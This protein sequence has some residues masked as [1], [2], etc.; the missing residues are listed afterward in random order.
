MSSTILHRDELTAGRASRAGPEPAAPERGREERNLSLSI[1]G[2]RVRHLRARRGMTRK[3]VAFAANVS[4]RHL[5]NLEYGIGNASFLV[6][7]Q[8]AL[9]LQ[10]PLAELVGD[11]TTSSPEWLLIRELLE[12]CDESTLRRARVAITASG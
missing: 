1:L 6:L 9:A 7:Q 5:A 12:H 11:V 2:E 3:A 10:C 4:E 8:V